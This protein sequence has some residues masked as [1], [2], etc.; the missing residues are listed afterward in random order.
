M[1]MAAAAAVC[2]MHMVCMCVLVVSVVVIVV[3]RTAF[4]V[5]LMCCGM[6]VIMLRGAA[7]F[8]GRFFDSSTR[9]LARF[10]A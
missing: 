6:R 2:G 8:A 4:Q 7:I 1:V 5:A 3:V 9:C 10:F